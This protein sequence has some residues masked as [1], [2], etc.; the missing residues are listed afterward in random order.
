MK[1]IGLL[2]IS[3]FC[4]PMIVNA[5]T[6]PRV[7]TLEAEAD[8][9]TVIYN[10]TTEGDISAVMCKLFDSNNKEVYKLSSAVENAAFSGE[11]NNVNNAG[12][13]TVACA[14]YE[15]GEIKTADVTIEA[16]AVMYSFTIDPNGGTILETDIPTSIPA[17]TEI[18]LEK[19]TAE[20]VKAPDGK[21]LDAYEVN[22]KRYEFNSKY[23]VNSDTVVKLLWK[24]IKGSENSSN[25]KTFDAGIR[26]SLILLAI[27]VAGASTATVYLKKKNKK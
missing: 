10:G 16:D 4:I 21:E 23:V 14:K 22:G 17:G 24:D 2:I 18:T 6:E 20:E 3:I 27:G 25:P 15:G 12:D 13:Y 5:A 7:A 26:N 9:N 8:G 11:F 19:L 1:K